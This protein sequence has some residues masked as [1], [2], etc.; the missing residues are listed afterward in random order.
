M[1]EKINQTTCVWMRARAHILTQMCLHVM[2]EFGV[3]KIPITIFII[4]G[5]IMAVFM[6][7]SLSYLSLSLSYLS[8][9]LW[10]PHNFATGGVG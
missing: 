9:C 2:L 10:Q 7:L 1:L 6:T 8:L 4:K 3:M 5:F